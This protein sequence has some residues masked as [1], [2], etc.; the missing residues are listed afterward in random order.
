M[1]SKWYEILH[2]A[3]AEGVVV[4]LH[5]SGG[6]T[7]GGKVIELNEHTVALD[8]NPYTIRVGNK[9]WVAYDAITAV[10]YDEHGHRS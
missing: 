1:T 7:V 4:K 3:Q 5:L 2:W 10:S 8:E 6:H 9:H